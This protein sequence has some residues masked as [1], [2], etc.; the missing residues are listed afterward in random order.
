MDNKKPQLH[1]EN[2]SVISLVSELHAYFKD[3][4]S[5]YQVSQ[6]EIISQLEASDDEKKE[7]QLKKKLREA[8]EKIAY[9]RV[10][11]DAFSI[12][13]TVLHTEAMIA[14]F[15]PEQKAKKVQ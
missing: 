7:Q 2:N 1:I 6:G 4:Q 3:S 8:N 10:L 15:G 13:D 5:Y 9:F 11:N 12:A 14:E